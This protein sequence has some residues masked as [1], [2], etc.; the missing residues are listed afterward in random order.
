VVGRISSMFFLHRLTLRGYQMSMAVERV[1]F[2]GGP[3]NLAKLENNP[4]SKIGEPD[5]YNRH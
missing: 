2:T 1:P 3:A 5:S 4:I